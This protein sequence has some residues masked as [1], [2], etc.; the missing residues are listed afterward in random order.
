MNVSKG[1]RNN[2]VNSPQGDRLQTPPVVFGGW[3]ISR[4][5]ITWL[6]SFDDQLVVW[7]ST[8]AS[9]WSRALTAI[10]RGRKTGEKGGDLPKYPLGVWGGLISLFAR[11]QF[12]TSSLPG[13]GQGWID[14]LF[15]LT[16]SDL[17]LN[18]LFTGQPLAVTSHRF[19]SRG[20]GEAADSLNL[21]IFFLKELF[22]I[23]EGRGGKKVSTKN[24]SERRGLRREEKLNL[25]K[26]P[27]RGAA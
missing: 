20:R 11:E 17:Y 26:F 15:Q 4:P 19:I 23:R 1:N 8:L 12:I 7:C 22:F 24:N 9:S 2:Q 16:Q 6:Q 10:F 18:R 14:R 21:I 27:K 13:Q 3:G 25:E 5:A